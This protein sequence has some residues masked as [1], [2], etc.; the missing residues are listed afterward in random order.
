MIKSAVGIIAAFLLLVGAAAEGKEPYVDGSAGDDTTTYAANSAATPWRTLGRAIW[1]SDSISAP[2][3]GEAAKAGDTV[4]VVAGV[5][6]TAA[7]TN[8]RY[9]PLYNPVNRGEDGQP[10]VIRS[11][12]PGAVILRS[13]QS[14]GSQPII[15]VLNNAHVAWS[16]FVIDER[17]VPTRADTGPVVVWNAQHVTL[18]NLTIRG[19]NRGWEDNHNGIRLEHVSDVV[20]RGNF[21]SGYVDPQ[22]N[23]NSNALT[24]YDGTRVTIENNEI[25]NANAGLHVKC[26]SPGPVTIRYNLIRGVG[27]GILFSG[28][29]AAVAYGN[30]LVNVSSG[31]AFNLYDET[32]GV[33][34][35]IVANNTIVG[36]APSGDNGAILLR[37]GSEFYRDVRLYN[38][39]IS[40]AGTCVTSYESSLSPAFSASHNAY[41]RCLG[42]FAQIASGKYTWAQWTKLFRRDTEGSGVV[43]DPG[44]VD[45]ANGDYRL[46]AV[47]VLRGAGVDILDLNGDG[48]TTDA[49][50]MGAYA[51]G[52]ETVG[53]NAPAIRDPYVDPRAE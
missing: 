10:I 9:S 13:S 16:G 20:V 18:E 36:A 23:H 21:I 35:V 15:G 12:L 41:H 2:D 39:V 5:Y 49:V 4:I 46:S 24:I 34:N 40:N 50:D 42:A 17:H 44:F 14:S 37:A 8:K 28:V 29:Q 6:D 32:H 19:Y 30:V 22:N 43:K 27:R 7:A 26:C 1:G 25:E 33:Q 48:S 53:R 3:K 52:N 31:V 45:P 38:N 47:S 51:L 11:Q